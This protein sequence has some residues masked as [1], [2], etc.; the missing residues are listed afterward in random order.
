[1]DVSRLAPYVGSIRMKNWSKWVHCHCGIVS[2]FIPTSCQ[3]K[4]FLD[5]LSFGSLHQIHGVVFSG[6]PSDPTSADDNIEGWFKLFKIHNVQRKIS[7][8]HAARGRLAS[9][10]ELT[11]TYDALGILEHSRRVGPMDPVVCTSSF[12]Q[13]ADQTGGVPRPLMLF[14]NEMS[15]YAFKSVARRRRLNNMDDKVVLRIKKFP[16]RFNDCLKPLCVILLQSGSS[17]F[18]ATNPLEMVNEPTSD[19]HDAAFFF[20][21]NEVSA[22]TQMDESPQMSISKTASLW[23]NYLSGCPHSTMW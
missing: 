10:C 19:I 11:H 17:P 8:S 4:R 3:I 5:R 22:V 12:I 23:W 7:E 13:H 14:N 2:A 21:F 6:I 16:P 20:A 9:C 15:L 18:V 1:M